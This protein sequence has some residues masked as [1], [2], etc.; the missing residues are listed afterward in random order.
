MSVQY[1]EK[2]EVAFSFPSLSVMT[3]RLVQLL[4][5]CW[6]H[7][8]HPAF[9]LPRSPPCPHPNPE[10]PRLKLEPWVSLNLK[11]KLKTIQ[12]KP[13]KKLGVIKRLQIVTIAEEWETPIILSSHFHS[14][15][16]CLWWALAVRVKKSF[17]HYV[18]PLVTS[19]ML[20][21]CWFLHAYLYAVYH[22]A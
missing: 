16:L 3:P 17:P 19:G 11:Q 20:G 18:F 22:T 5:A 2:L 6:P 9:T 10:L 7:P 8:I 4:G 21:S 12:S 13:G 14:S 1:R 15:W